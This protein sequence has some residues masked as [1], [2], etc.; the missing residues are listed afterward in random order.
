MRPCMIEKLGF[1]LFL[2]LHMAVSGLIITHADENSVITVAAALAGDPRVTLGERF[3]L[4]RA[5][6][7]ETSSPEGD[8]DLIDDLRARA[9][10]V[11]VDVV[12]V[13]LDD[14]TKRSTCNAER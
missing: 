3:G 13:H 1:S 6:V 4:R 5:V 7:G 10:V 14:L 9:G 8:R 11:N 12:Y 2:E